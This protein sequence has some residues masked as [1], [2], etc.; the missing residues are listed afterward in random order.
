[1]TFATFLLRKINCATPRAVPGLKRNLNLMRAWF[2]QSL[3]SKIPLQ[4]SLKCS[5]YL[6]QQFV[7]ITIIFKLT[8]GN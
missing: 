6:L 5:R 2:Q 4:N 8:V 3:V 7:L 1:M